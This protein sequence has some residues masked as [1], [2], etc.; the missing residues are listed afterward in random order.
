MS[1]GSVHVRGSTKIIDV[2]PNLASFSTPYSS[3]DVMGSV[4]TLTNIVQEVRGTAIIESIIVLDKSNQ[5]GAIDL[6]FFESAPIS[7]IG[8]DNAAYALSDSDL[9]L[10]LGRISFVATDYASSSTNNSEATLR[11]IGLVVQPAASLVSTTAVQ[12]IP[13]STGR[14][15]YMAVVCRGAVT[16]GSAS[17]LIIR[18]GFL[19]D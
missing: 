13:Q 12:K 8:A 18:V 19:Q 3:G 15:I 7:S 17:S 10:V 14:N 16:H 9:P 11:T 4:N 6:V 1:G 2:T 5:S